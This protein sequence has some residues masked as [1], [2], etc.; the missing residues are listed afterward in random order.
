MRRLAP[1]VKSRRRPL[2]DGSRFIGLIA[3]AMRGDR[4]KCLKTGMDAYL[5]KPVEPEA[6]YDA[7]AR[8]VSGGD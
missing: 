4:E 6:L 7:I 5:P 2:Q 1:S 8:S 3:H